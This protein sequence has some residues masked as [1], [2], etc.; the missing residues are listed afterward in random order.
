MRAAQEGIPLS[1]LEVRVEWDY[2]SRGML[3]VDDSLP[4]GPLGVRVYYRLG[5]DGVSEERL[6]EL[7]EWAEAHSP[8]G[9]V[10][11]RA[12]DYEVNLEII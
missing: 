11:R 6:E 9:D 5:A 1:T 10:F 2:D 12:M 8:V 3:G 7:V 4:A